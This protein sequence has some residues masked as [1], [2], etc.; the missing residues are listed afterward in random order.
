MVYIMEFYVD[1]ACRGNGKPGAIGAAACC[2][3]RKNGSFDVRTKRLRRRPAPTNQR[4][5][6]TGIIEALLWAFERSKKLHSSPWLD[7][8]I[9]TDSKYAIGCMTTWIDKWANNGWVN[10]SG[11]EVANRDIIELAYE[12]EDMVKEIGTVSYK[13]IPR[14]KNTLADSYCNEMLDE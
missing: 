2:Y 5:E 7:I 4:A 1:G 13:W 12:I 10:S 11:N 9:H 3:V 14:S 6:I 8:R